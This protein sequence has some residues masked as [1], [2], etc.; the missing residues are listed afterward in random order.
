[1]SRAANARTPQEDGGSAHQGTI[2]NLRAFMQAQAQSQSITR[3]PQ[4][5]GPQQS[6]QYAQVR[7]SVRI[8]VRLVLL[9][10]QQQFEQ[11]I[12]YNESECAS[13]SIGRDEWCIS[14]Q[15]LNFGRSELG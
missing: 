2:S 3:T 7:E 15:F 10:P 4:A 13:D 11:K 9:M 6:P 12:Y 1:M 5:R 8:E 14:F